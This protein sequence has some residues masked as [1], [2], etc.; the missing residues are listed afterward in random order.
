MPE[1]GGSARVSRVAAWMGIAFAVLFVAG[2]FVPPTAK[3]QSNTLEWA[4]LWNTSGHRTSAIIGAYLLILGMLAFI[5][6]A[7]S[8]RARIGDGSGMMLA[9]AVLF[10]VFAMAAG[11]IGATIAGAKVFTNAPIPAGALSQQLNSLAGGLIVV[12]GGLAAGAFVGVA[13]HLA[14]RAG[15]LPGWLTIAGYIVAILQLAAVLFL[16]LLLVPL[17]V[18][19]VSI[20]LLRSE[21][22]TPA[23]A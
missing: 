22:K 2:N 10:A 20:V 21:S 11:L 8:F 23:T 16:P 18:L 14:R 4:Q 17:W 1:D 6:F 9:F 7:S 12:P 15:V 13:A 5:Y 19:V 3:H